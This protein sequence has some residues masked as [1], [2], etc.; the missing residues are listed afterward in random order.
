MENML[1]LIKLPIG[2]VENETE[3]FLVLGRVVIVRLKDLQASTFLA[4]VGG[5][6]K[7]EQYEE[8]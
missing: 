1:L 4:M 3:R 8:N 2:V 5:D 6:D 7:E